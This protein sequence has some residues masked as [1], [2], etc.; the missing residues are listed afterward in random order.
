MVSRGKFTSSGSTPISPAVSGSWERTAGNFFRAPLNV[1]GTNLNTTRTS[2][3]DVHG[4]DLGTDDCVLA[5]FVSPEPLNVDQTITGTFSLVVGG[6]SATSIDNLWL[7]VIARV[8]KPDGTER[9]V[10]L[11]QT[12]DSGALKYGTTDRTRIWSALS[13]TS[14]A[15]LAGDYI[16]V[17]VGSHSAVAGVGAQ[18]T[19]WFGDPTGASDSALTAGLATTNV[20]WCEFSQT[21]TFGVPI[22]P[23]TPSAA[24]APIVAPSPSLAL[25]LT[26]TPSAAS[27]PA[28]APSPTLAFGT[29]TLTP[30]AAS[31][32]AT[33]PSPTLAFGTATLTPSA[34][35]SAAIAPS[36]ALALE[37]VLTPTPAT[38]SAAAPSASLAMLLT[39][40][41]TP[42][43]SPID[44]PFVALAMLLELAPTAASSAAIAPSVA[45]AFELVLTP[46]PATW[47][48]TAPACTL[49][50]VLTLAPSPAVV[51]LV[52]PSVAGNFDLT[53]QAASTSLE[54][55]AVSRVLLLAPAVSS[56]VLEAPS[57]SLAMLLTLPA[58]PAD[59]RIIARQPALF[60]E[61]VLTPEAATFSLLAPD[62]DADAPLTLT[63]ASA[64]TPLDVPAVSLLRELVLTPA[65]A[66][67]PLV[68]PAVDALL[69]LTPS[70]ATF[71][72]A[73]PNGALALELF[74]VLA[75]RGGAVP[76][77]LTAP[78]VVTVLEVLLGQAGQPVPGTVLVAPPVSLSFEIRLTPD[79]AA[80]VLVAPPAGSTGALTLSPDPAVVDLEAPS[81]SFGGDLVLTPD[82]VPLAALAPAVLIFPP[83]LLPSRTPS[84]ATFSLVALPVLVTMPGIS[85]NVLGSGPGVVL[86]I[87][88]TVSLLF[89]TST[90]RPSR[91]LDTR[92]AQALGLDRA[93]AQAPGGTRLART[94]SLDRWPPV[95]GPGP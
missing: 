31:S 6:F 94:L 11:V 37:L 52:A 86:L 92:R 69:V 82:P 39:L 18:V 62:A 80:V 21:L 56:T 15:A 12:T 3:V 20:H 74:I 7:A 68:A 48:A 14:V 44:A 95:T 33:A 50:L 61:L 29:A 73:A 54:V 19:M 76:F 38:W 25:L 83:V 27:S 57:T 45:L 26:L 22:P 42:A 93:L 32:A 75:G 1:S 77:L 84:P 43:P 30:S 23:I 91:T 89:W 35:S 16:V 58:N 28:A 9:G 41:P 53:P 85:Q 78:N 90:A 66:Q 2:F 70:P 71:Q 17:E 72:V 87:S 51:A 4:N 46:T 79:P 36:V 49:A 67:A 64:S 13:V 5:Q 55:P 40:N 65:A 10:L 60:L 81:V 34:A 24:A 88:P 47:S 59:V 63:P 8:I